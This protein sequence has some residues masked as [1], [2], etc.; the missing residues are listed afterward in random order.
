[1][2]HLQ[3]HFAT[4]GT[5]ELM[6]LTGR[7]RFLCTLPLYYSVG[8]NSCLGH[9][10]RGDCIILCP[11]WFSAQEYVEIACKHQ[12]TVAVVVPSMVRLLLAAAA[13]RPLLPGLTAMFCT[14]AP[15]YADEK[16]RAVRQLTPTFHERYGTSETLAIAVLRPGDIAERADSVGQPHSLG[17]VEIVDDDGRPLPPNRSGRLRF[18]GP[19][20]ATPLSGS[21]PSENF[22]DGW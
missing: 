6:G 22:R 4:A 8:R 21:A 2:T 7:H 5:F 18:R 16:R 17:E 12:A 11:S 1:M 3:Y 9:L 19:G 10:L 13:D 14:G 20:L 15:L